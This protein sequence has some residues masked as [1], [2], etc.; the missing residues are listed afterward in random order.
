MNA[1]NP[2]APTTVVAAM[3][4]DRM[5]TSFYDDIDFVLQIQVTDAR[6]IPTVAFHDRVVH[7]ETSVAQTA[8]FGSSCLGSVGDSSGLD[9]NGTSTVRNMEQEARSMMRGSDQFERQHEYLRKKR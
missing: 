9:P 1:M 2:R 5:G 8:R 3:L 7:C 6:V 4:T